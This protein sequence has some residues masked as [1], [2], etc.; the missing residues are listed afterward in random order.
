MVV[1]QVIGGD[2]GVRCRPV[3]AFP[4]KKDQP[5]QPEEPLCSPDPH[6]RPEPGVVRPVEDAD[7][8]IGGQHGL[9]TRTNRA[10]ETPRLTK[11]W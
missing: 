9:L 1:L 7:M 4:T 10:I 6:A 5:D 11:T 8:A 2:D 3:H